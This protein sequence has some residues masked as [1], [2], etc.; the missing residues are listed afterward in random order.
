MIVVDSH[1]DLAWNMLTF[2][3]DYTRSVE[4]TRQVEAGGQTP[5]R[6]GDSLLGWPEYQRG[7]VAVVFA[8]LFAAPAR[9]K[10]GDWEKLS[11]ANT[12]QAHR[13]YS[14]QID[15]YQQLADE[16]H[17]KFQLVQSLQDLNTILAGGIT[18]PSSSPRSG[19]S[20]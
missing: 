16:H 2:G 3:R 4:E 12:A 5:L 6:N 1:Q 8:T 10:M 7:E 19:W 9:H 18:Q 17:D 13:I 20:F 11:Y 15:L 14:T